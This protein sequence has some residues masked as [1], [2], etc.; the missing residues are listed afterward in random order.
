MMLHT[1]TRFRVVVKRLV[2]IAEPE[3]HIRIGNRQVLDADI[4]GMPAGRPGEGVTKGYF[5]KQ[6]NRRGRQLGRVLATR[7]EE[8]II[9]RL[10]DGKRQLHR[11]LKELLTS[12]E[13]VLELIENCTVR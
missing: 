6:C 4:T 5:P 10:Y 7:Y 3:K 9:D 12:T 2:K 8:I 11:S 1:L 13:E